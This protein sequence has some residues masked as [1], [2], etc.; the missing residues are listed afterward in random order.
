MDLEI[1]PQITER[2]LVD[3]PY[4]PAQA[5][6]VRIYLFSHCEL[7]HIALHYICGKGSGFSLVGTANE[8]P[9]RFETLAAIKPDLII[10]DADLLAAS[11]ARAMEMLLRQI[12]EVA[13]IIVLASHLDV[14]RACVAVASGADGYILTS[15]S[16]DTFLRALHVVAA[17]GIWLGEEL[18]RTI[19]GQLAD[20]HHDD[21]TPVARLL[22]QRERQILNCVAR[23]ETSKEIARQL[24]LSESSVRTYW[25]RVLGKLNALN[26]AEAVARAARL[27]LL[28]TGMD[29]DDD[30]LLTVSP[31]L[32]ALVQQRVQHGRNED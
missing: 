13:R 14:T 7:R 21:T 20:P 2:Q 4:W 12:R 1:E 31:R 19:A 3:N 24:Y 5:A 28:D 9:E 6:D 8:L 23:G 10:I 11:R 29:D 15:V 25:Y 26:K 27:G 30:A 22:S 32:R 18:A 17:G 16:I